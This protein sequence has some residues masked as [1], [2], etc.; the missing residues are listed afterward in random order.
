MRVW[1]LFSIF[2]VFL[3]G[4]RGDVTRRVFAST[5]TG[6]TAHQTPQP[7]AHRSSGPDGVPLTL[8]GRARSSA[9]RPPR[10]G[11]ASAPTWTS[12]RARYIILRTRSPSH[13]R[14][15]SRRPAGPGS[16]PRACR[17]SAR[18]RAV[19]PPREG[20]RD[21]DR[22]G[23]RSSG[24]RRRD[25]PTVDAT[26]TPARARTRAPSRTARAWRDTAR[27]PET[28][29]SHRPDRRRASLVAAAASGVGHAVSAPAGGRQRRD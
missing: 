13:A 7:D 2:R 28:R 14:L 12:P 9:P 11:V 4:R 5:T 19:A 17:V 16:G 6:L 24:A 1:I 25:A 29:T 10:S 22:H 23:A 26:S 3:P 20:R 27:T 21:A 15:A 8:S 18:P